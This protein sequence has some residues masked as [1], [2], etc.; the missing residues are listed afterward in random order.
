MSRLALGPIH[1]PIQWVSEALSLGKS[2]WSV[3][4][5]IDPHLLPRL[6]MSRA[7]A[8]LS[9]MPTLHVLGHQYLIVPLGHPIF[10][11]VG[12]REIGAGL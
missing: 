8:L 2:G 1:P 5:T 11:S 7:V 9:Y 4:L 10:N 12:M 3:K 6:R